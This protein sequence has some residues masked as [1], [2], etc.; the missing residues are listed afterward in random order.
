MVTAREWVCFA[1]IPLILGCTA[2][3]LCRVRAVKILFWAAVYL[4]GVAVIAITL[5][6]MPLWCAGSVS[7]VMGNAVPLRS[8]ARILRVCS[9]DEA[10]W[11]IGG[12]ILLAVP[13]GVLLGRY[14]KGRKRWLL[15]LLPWVFP[16][17]IEGAQL[18][19]GHMLGVMYR[20]V[21]VDD[22]LLNALGGYLG[23]G[24][25]TACGKRG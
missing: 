6:P 20:S 2:A 7:P 19:L 17:V 1:L 22:V 3:G 10:F 18:V 4:Y 23:A 16:V 13:Y 5:F 11:Q 21:D 8:I 15:V 25:S 14:L 12:N 9:K 24:L